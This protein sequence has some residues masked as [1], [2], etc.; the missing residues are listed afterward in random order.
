MMV[1][2]VVV[3]GELPQREDTIVWVVVAAVVENEAEQ[4]KKIARVVVDYCWS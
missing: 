3:T 1:M 4:E 2:G